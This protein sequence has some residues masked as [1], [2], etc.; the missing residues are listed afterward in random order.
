MRRMARKVPPVCS[1]Q[2]IDLVDLA[3][4]RAIVRKIRREPR[5]FMRAR[6]T[7]AQWEKKHRS[8]MPAWR[9]WKVLLERND[10]NAVL[11]ILTRTD[12]E[13]QRLRSTAPFCGI[14]SPREVEAVWA[15]YD[16]KPIGKPV[17][18]RG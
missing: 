18:S 15:R 12:D 13:G 17:A 3:M 7:L 9:E 1:H 10:M 16:P 6:R 5:L 4:H 14:L 2:W 8:S 11:R